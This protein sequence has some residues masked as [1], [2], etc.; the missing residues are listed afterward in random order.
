M[1]SFDK[2]KF[3]T[4]FLPKK[5]ELEKTQASELRSLIDKYKSLNKL[6]SPEFYDRR[7]EMKK[8]QFKEFIELAINSLIG[9]IA[10][11][12][13]ID[14]G[15]IK[16]FE[17]I[18]TELSTSYLEH[19][20]AILKTAMISYGNTDDSP[21]VTE[22]VKAYEKQLSAVRISTMEQL[23]IKITNHENNVKIGSA[24][25][26]KNEGSW[27]KYNALIIIGIIVVVLCITVLY[28]IL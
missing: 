5:Y 25:E 4:G 21:I 7:I 27:K 23:T 12:T 9:T 15:D 10:F 19:E 2:E 18:L 28:F 14:D 3:E 11:K 16:T 20:K 8:R 17:E 24:G 26:F 13:K 1:G 6:G 22:T